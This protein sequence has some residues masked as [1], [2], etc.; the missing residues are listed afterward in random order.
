VY[1]T[2]RKIKASREQLPET[3]GEGMGGFITE[4]RQPIGATVTGGTQ[5]RTAFQKRTI[6]TKTGS[7]RSNQSSGRFRGKKRRSLRRKDKRATAARV[8][9]R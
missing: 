6:Y 8:K 4:G 3:W 1:G 5:G 9:R 7:G 2:P